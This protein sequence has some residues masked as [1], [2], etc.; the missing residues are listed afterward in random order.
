MR[1]HECDKRGK[2]QILLSV[3]MVVIDALIVIKKDL[4]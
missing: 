3:R 1:C 4:E 2:K